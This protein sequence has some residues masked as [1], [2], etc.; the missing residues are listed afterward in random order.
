[1]ILLR[2]QVSDFAI[3]QKKS[4]T[5]LGLVLVLALLSLQLL[6]LFCC[7]TPQMAFAE[8][9]IDIVDLSKASDSYDHQQIVFDAEVVGDVINADDGY[10]WVTLNDGTASIS[11]YI[12]Q[13]SRDSVIN[14]GSYSSRGTTLHVQGEFNLACDVH[15]GL[16][17]IHALQTTVI[18]PGGPSEH[19]FN[20]V[21]LGAGIL[22]IIFGLALVTLYKLIRKRKI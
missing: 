6:L 22:L 1:M 14:L 15:D 18:D 12:N 16:S 7:L 5:K 3:K 21:I 20:P 10:Y 19:P 9:S 2:R 8:D 4:F 17:D 11:V 13:T